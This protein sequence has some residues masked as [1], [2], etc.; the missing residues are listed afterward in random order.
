MRKLFQKSF[1]LPLIVVLAV[2]LVIYKV[3]SKPP[4][5]HA[6]LQYPE[7][8][9]EVIT[10]KEIPF[11]ARATAYGNVEPAVLLKAKAEVSGKI[12]YIHP[13]LKQ[14]GSLA[15]GTVVLR[16]EPTIFEF[17]LEQSKAGLVGSRS[18]L[19]QLEVEEK[20]SY[21]SLALAKKN[22]LVGEKEL[23]RLR[24]IRE[25]GLI[26]RSA[27]DAEEQKVLGLRQQVEDL[28]G[29]L[30]AY[31][32]RKAATEAQI[33]QSESQL[34]QSQDTLQRTEV[35][36]PFD[37]RIGEVFV[38]KDEFTPAGNVLFE[39]LGVQA[40][41]INAQLTT[42]QFRPLLVGMGKQKMAFQGVN[43]LQAAL[44]KMKL[45]AKVSLVSFEGEG[46]I[47]WQGELSRI[48]E[49]ID[50]TRDTLGL[51]VVV[52]KPYEDVI[53]GRRPPLM[54]GMYVAVE[55]LAP[56]QNQLV[57]PRKAIHQGRVYVVDKNEKLEIRPVKII[58]KQ[59]ELAVISEG[60]KQGEKI[61]VTDVVP[62]ISGLPLN[63]MYSVKLEEQLA[64]DALGEK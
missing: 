8:T 47:G 37:A 58:H 48:G 20:A 32:S 55:F 56:A 59:G 29:K 25:K 11:R 28:Q 9:V 21:S 19:K 43:D 44:K 31:K 23:N 62:V 16:I 36:M 3:K 39:A 40:V 61:I 2:A 26:A 6:D 34:S 17:S 24:V 60:L 5:A 15:K 63:V 64:I 4:I 46:A 14:G 1:I 10:L 41:E 51:V 7:K 52:K 22:L 30:E 50:P 54:K 57:V 18:S 12:S 27:V 38:E 35:R 53:P 49:S 13:S 45:E 42:Q 33:T